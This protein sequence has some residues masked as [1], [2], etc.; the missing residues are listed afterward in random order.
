MTNMRKTLLSGLFSLTLL[1]VGGHLAAQCSFEGQVID[2]S[3]SSTCSKVILSYDN[4]EILAPLDASALS[5]IDIGAEI[6]FSYTLD[7]LGQACAAGIP[8]LLTCVEVTNQPAPDCIADFV[9][10][11]DF[12]NNYPVASF[13]PLAV[14][15]NLQ[16]TWDFGDGEI[17]YEPI[18]TH[19]FSGQGFYEVCLTLSGGN[20]GQTVNCQTVDLN[21]C[22]AAFHT[23]GNDGTVN[24][25]NTSSGNYTDWEWSLGN[26]AELQNTFLETFDYGEINIYTVCLTVWNNNGCSS[27]Y[28]DYV[29]TGSG[30]VCEFATCVYPG[31]TNWDGSA[32]VYDLLPIGVGHGT[33]G[34]P[35]QL[36]DVDLALDWSPQ[37][38]PDWGLE[39]INGNDYKHLD[40]NGDGNVDGEDVE[41]IE[42]NYAAPSNIFMVQANGAPTVWLD[43]E[44]D[45]ILIDDNT[46]ATIELEADLMIGTPDLP[47]EN[48]RGFALQMNYPEDKVVSGGIEVDYSD[49]S[50][51]GN[52]NHILWLQKDRYDDGGEFDLGFTKKSAAAEGFGKIATVKFIVISDVLARDQSATQFTVSLEDVVAVNPDG[53]MLTIG[54][55]LPSTVY[56]VNKMT[57]ATNNEWLN[58]QVTVFPNPATEKAIV[59]INDLK[60]E[61]L[62]VFNALGQ[63]V[64]AETGSSD[65]FELNTADWEKGIYLIK[66]QTDQ[67]MANKRLVVQ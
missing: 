16:Y 61:Q 49:N 22:H 27:K 66:I 64:Q 58:S 53:A 21:E 23:E 28:C 41:A 6:Q 56:V 36:D 60:A 52:S 12:D 51:F 5:T 59:Q 19:A 45:T 25:F 57:T 40:C 2:L 33:E 29:F 10:F 35:R 14:D 32:N 67:G 55:L 1:L 44:W 38:A 11:A 37:Y 39:T 46:P 26:G 30:D 43:F 7:T 3:S 4:F 50:F 15:A 8:I 17:A 20:C 18:V 62:E 65:Y 48:L 34:P 24:F 13:Q 42:V 9:F 54:E 31:D 63:K 47:M